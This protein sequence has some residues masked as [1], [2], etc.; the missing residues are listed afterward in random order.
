V[1]LTD[2]DREILNSR[3]YMRMATLMP[4]GSP[5]VT[6]LWFRLA[7]DVL[8]VICPQSAQKVKNVDRDARVSAVIEDPETP[9][10]F[11]ELRGNC[12]AVR[13]DAGARIEMVRIARRYIG[14]EA[15][16][17]AAGLSEDPRV[18]LRLIPERV[19]RHGV[20]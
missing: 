7:D 15:E 20:S 4:D 11:I 14:D 1:R 17:F 19:I 8:Q 6:V 12:E 10:R 18:I 3:S 16:G 2:S 5:Q 13:D 9:H